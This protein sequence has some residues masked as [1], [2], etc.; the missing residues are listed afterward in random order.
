MPQLSRVKVAGYLTFLILIWGINWPLSKFALAYAPPILFAGLRTFVA[1]IILLAFALTRYK[2]LRFKETWPI[3]VLASVLNIVLYYGFQ[4]VGLQYMPAGL[5]SAIVFFQPV[6]L[7][8]FSWLWFGEMMY[9]LKMVG[10]LLGFAGVSVMSI[11]GFSGNISGWGIILAIAS[12]LSWAMGS[13][14]MKKQAAQVDSVWM[15]T[16]QMLIGGIVMLASGSFMESWTDI[17]WSS[18]FIGVTLFI[19]VFVIALGW[20][21]YFTLIGTGEASK[22]GSFTF[23]IPVVSILISVMFFHEKVTASL[24]TGLVLIAFSILFVNVKPKRYRLQA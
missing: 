5:F 14:Y 17:V 7:G 4:T 22:V 24:L 2:Q 21:V 8:I 6:L 20:L 12:A 18:S 15:T 19:S 23:L 9:G 13:L 3:Y 1:G 10:L 11:G 16:M